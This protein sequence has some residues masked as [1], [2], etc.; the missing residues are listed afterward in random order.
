MPPEEPTSW[1][2]VRDATRTGGVAPQE[3]RD[4]AGFYQREFPFI[5]GPKDEDCLNLNIW[6]PDVFGKLPV[7]VWIH[8]GAFNHG[9]GS[10]PVFDGVA[11]AKRGVVVVTINYR[12]GMLGYLCH[13]ALEG[14]RGTSGNY[15]L[16]DQIMALRY[17]KQCIASFGGD[18][19]N[20]TVFGQ[21]AGGMSVLC[22][23]AAPDA[24]GLFHRAVVQSGAMRFSPGMP[25]V[26][27][28]DALAMGKA[29]AAKLG[30][31][32]LEAL[33]ALDVDDILR[34]QRGV[35]YAPVYD[36]VVLP[37]DIP[38]AIEQGQWNRVPVVAGYVS[39]ESGANYEPGD[40]EP[41]SVY[42]ARIREQY[43]DKAAS[44]LS[45]YPATD[46]HATIAMRMAHD[47]DIAYLGTTRLLDAIGTGGGAAYG[48]RFAMDPPGEGGSFHGAFHSSELAYVFGTLD[49]IPR[50]W[51]PCDRQ[52]SDKIM[53]A[54]VAFASSGAPAT[55]GAP[56]WPLWRDGKC[57]MQWSEPVALLSPADLDR[58]LALGGI[59]GA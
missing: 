42:E 14:E 34:A 1:P 36:G 57:L 30:A 3:D 21:S 52:L 27:Y 17:V 46:E 56:E 55:P 6:T 53:D 50:P 15:G 5:Y 25:K 48:Y 47:A 26:T 58:A 18:P 9:A 13:P 29:E 11:L 2:G 40:T 12:M 35:R 4:P 37:R 33:Q 51:R 39:N 59:V 43:G 54:Y 23:L 22:L 38:A 32:T 31:D 16:L 20:V 49:K 7:M 41:V 24:K 28:Q 8:G 45:L 10:D 19:D 44:V